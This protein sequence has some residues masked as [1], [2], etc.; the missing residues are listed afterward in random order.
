MY[1]EMFLIVKGL[2]KSALNHSWKVERYYRRLLG[3]LTRKERN[4]C[5]NEPLKSIKYPLNQG[6]PCPI[7]S[8]SSKGHKIEQIQNLSL[9]FHRTFQYKYK[10]SGALTILF[11]MQLMA[12][13]LWI[14][15]NDLK[16]LAK[17]YIMGRSRN[18]N[19]TKHDA[20]KIHSDIVQLYKTH[21]R[22]VQIDR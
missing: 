1:L 2:Q 20:I 11:K 8:F 22:N 10:R 14:A 13:P 18:V 7:R 4:A 19:L 12:T 15:Y 21:I 5:Y 9:Y 16:V 17:H 3:P 6:V